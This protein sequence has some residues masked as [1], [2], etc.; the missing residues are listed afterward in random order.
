VLLEDGK[1]FYSSD[2]LLFIFAALALGPGSA[3]AKQWQRGT[4]TEKILKLT[5]KKMFVI[6]TTKN[7]R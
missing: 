7:Y 5:L 1:P 4:G 2:S 3:P 6:S